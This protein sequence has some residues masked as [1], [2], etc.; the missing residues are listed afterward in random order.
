RTREFLRYSQKFQISSTIQELREVKESKKMKEELE[1]YC[2]SQLGP[3]AV[4]R[5]FSARVYDKGGELAFFYLGNRW[6]DEKKEDQ[7]MH[8][9]S[10]LYNGYSDS[11]LT[12]GLNGGREMV[13]DGIQRDSHMLLCYQQATQKLSSILQPISEGDKR[14]PS[15]VQSED[16]LQDPCLMRY[17]IQQGGQDDGTGIMVTGGRSERCG[18][19]H[20][21]QGWIQQNQPGKFVL[22]LVGNGLFLSTAFTQSSSALC[23]I[24]CYLNATEGLASCLGTMF[25]E[26]FPSVYA[27]YRKAFDAG[28][29]LEEDPGPWL[30]RAIVYKLQVMLHTDQNDAGP[31]VSF[32]CGFFHGGEMQIPQFPGKFTYHPGHICLFLSADIFHKVAQWTPDCM[33]S[34][35]E[36]T[37]GRIGSVFFFPEKSFELLCNKPAGW[38]KRTGYGAWDQFFD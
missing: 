35:V 17:E 10:E 36:L 19:H 38:G 13:C 18:V 37:P 21:V 33:Q 14:Y 6:K 9:I 1:E 8:P 25:E 32:P 30:G 5:P 31:T 16:P 7:P 34:Q 28:V 23:A 26:I 20:I 4:S 29:W 24:R 27:Q 3:N 15:Q 12:E 22:I 2:T 11:D